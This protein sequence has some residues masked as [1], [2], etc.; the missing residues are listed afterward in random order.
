M[1]KNNYLLKMGHMDK[2]QATFKQL[3]LRDFKK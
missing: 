3:A 1:I 2:K